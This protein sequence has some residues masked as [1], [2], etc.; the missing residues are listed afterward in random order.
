MFSSI[1][2]NLA[3]SSLIARMSAFVIVG[4]WTSPPSFTIGA[5][6]GFAV[7][8]INER[9]PSDINDREKFKDFQL[10]SAKGF[11]ELANLGEYDIPN[12]EQYILGLKFEEPIDSKTFK[13]PYEADRVLYNMSKKADKND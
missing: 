7:L 4:A 12:K 8:A 1:A 10:K 5:T 9:I 11:K 6:D 2:F 3:L 13:R